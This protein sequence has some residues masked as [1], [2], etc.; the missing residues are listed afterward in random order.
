MRDSFERYR[1]H[2]TP[3]N[4]L[5]LL[6]ACQTSVYN[7]CW[8]VLRHAHDAEDA[9]QDILLELI[10]GRDTVADAEHFVRWMYRVAYNTAIDRKRRR[11]RH[12]ELSP[13]AA[14]SEAS[15]PSADPN[16]AIHAAIARLDDEARS[17]VT[18]HF[19][20]KVTLEELGREQGCS[21]VAVWK[22]IEKAKDMLRRALAV[23][24]MALTLETTLEA[25][26]PA[27][28]PV[29]MA[30]KVFSRKA[31]LWI[32]PAVILAGGLVAKKLALTLVAVVA[33]AILFLAGIFA[34]AYIKP[35]SVN[36]DRERVAAL[37]RDLTN[38]RRELAAVRSRS[39]RSTDAQ[40]AR[41]QVT[42]RQGVA[43]ADPPDLK[44]RLLNH[45]RWIR[46]AW[47]EGTAIQ[48]QEGE[49][50]PRL[51]QLAERIGE[52]KNEAENQ[53]RELVLKDPVPFLEVIRASG[54]EMDL[55]L[56]MSILEK[57]VMTGA[58]GFHYSSQAYQKLPRELME[59]LVNILKMGSVSQRTA[60]LQFMRMIDEQPQHLRSV[61]QDLLKD[62]NQAVMAGVLGVLNHMR[63]PIPS[64]HVPALCSVI[65]SSSDTI[66]THE[67][68]YAFK[69]MKVPG[70][71]EYLLQ[72]FETN[73]N[74]RLVDTFLYS[75]DVEKADAPTQARFVNA[76]VG[77]LNFGLEEHIYTRLLSRALT[78]PLETA[79]VVF[80][81]A[82][83]RAPDDEW[84]AA[85]AEIADRIRKGERD[86]TP[87]HQL[88][89]KVQLRGREAGNAIM[90]PAVPD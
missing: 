11:I 3:E 37:E 19:F 39:N 89:S 25:A 23:A 10:R 66:L 51:Q 52:R 56:L 79:V 62:S 42:D 17:L 13:V 74:P 60:I 21:V 12:A 4:L 18:R 61:Y 9:A 48:A 58:K 7:V 85:V 90:V 29:G 5:S 45:L 86:V 44:T 88:L 27:V 81:Y 28:A 43:T 68:I 40:I 72:R 31:L 8:Q 87:F 50:S 53:L 15:G 64:E 22:K 55:H 35:Q 24:P 59:G 1:Q 70:S 80:E 65:E 63:W 47:Q 34:G 46:E 38:A 49:R 33:A 2:P 67:A 30:E 69:E 76:M 20:E 78:L 32:S 57:R 54:D 71:E 26:E 41:A 73:R 16:E 77:A 82:G 6:K 36:S 75:V 84:R 14:R 83:A